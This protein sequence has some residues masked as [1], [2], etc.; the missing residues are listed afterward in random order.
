MMRRFGFPTRRGLAAA[1]LTAAGFAVIPAV[2]F[3]QTHDDDIVRVIVREVGRVTKESAIQQGR[4]GG[5]QDRNFRTEL[6]D[7]ETRTLSLGATG[8]LELKN[9][10]GDISVSAGN[11]RDA[12]IE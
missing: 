4:G 3:A 11:G 8:S 6:T 2:T 7:K 5:S 10:S 1:A 9:V 12:T